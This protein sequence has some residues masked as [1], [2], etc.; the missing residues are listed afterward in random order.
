[1][2][3]YFQFILFYTKAKL[4]AE[5]FRHFAGYLWWILDPLFSVAV[6]YILFKLILN[7][8]GDDY[9]QYL[10]IGL[11]VWK[12]FGDSVGKGSGA[13][14]GSLGLMK[15]IAI[16]KHIFPTIEVL[17][18]TWKFIVIF[19]FIIVLYGLIGYDVTLYHFSL[20]VLM[21]SQF[22]LILGSV[23]FF[24]SILPFFPD[25]NFI[26]TYSLRL[27]FYPSGVLFS[28]DAVP[29]KYL[30]YIKLNPMAGL[31]DSYRNVIMKGSAP[32][33]FSIFYC[34]IIGVVLGVVGLM[35]IRKY[36]L[37]YPKLS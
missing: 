33:L 32:D 23:F 3:N 8:G 14:L 16:K 37:E 25:L 15:K 35:I 28:L 29:E 20:P 26:I 6:Y 1:M 7:R 17:Y 13:I 31:I 11:I 4:Q 24:S 22:V 21:I 30:K 18:N 36:E 19:V 12:W 10:F 27:V 2:K 34:I 5:T 9:I